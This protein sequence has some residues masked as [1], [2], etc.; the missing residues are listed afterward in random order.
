[1][2]LRK[3]PWQKDDAVPRSPALKF[4]WLLQS[5]PSLD[6]SLFRLHEKNLGF[7]SRFTVE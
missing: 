3:A 2:T 1:M 4:S 7:R 6:P 5:E